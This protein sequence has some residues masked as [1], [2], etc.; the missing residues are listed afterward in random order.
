MRKKFFLLFLLFFI[1]LNYWF[2]SNLSPS[3][4]DFS[5]TFRTSFRIERGQG[6]REVA[7]LLSQK[8]LIKSISA[9]KLYG[10]F[11]GQIDKI[12]PGIYQVDS[13]MSVPQIFNLLTYKPIEI[14]ITIPEGTTVRDID[15]ILARNN[16]I[17]PNELTNFSFA[18]FRESNLVEKYP[19]LTGLDNLEGFLYP[20]TYYFQ[21]WD[22][23]E[24]VVDKFLVNFEKEIWSKIKDKE[25]WFDILILSSIL[26]KEVLTL[27]DK[28]LVAGILLKRLEI[29]MPLQVDATI[30][31]DKCEGRF[32]SCPS[33][34][35]K[36]AR[37]DFDRDF[38]FNTYKNLGLPPFPICNPGL[39]SLEASLSPLK[40]QYLYYLSASETKETIFSK[41]NEEHNRNR[42]IYLR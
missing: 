10:L 23:L 18:S 30:V 40:S 16:L 8:N 41:T 4:G 27:K 13:S 31:Y 42:Q 38:P 7:G 26:E 15:E 25:N 37:S 2:F 14:K 39:K 11:S 5:H 28:K 17:L 29:N 21:K 1:L 20:D 9:F 34:L 24:E 32:F 36:L 12:Q 3:K 35:L 19:F 22:S 33:Y 6:I